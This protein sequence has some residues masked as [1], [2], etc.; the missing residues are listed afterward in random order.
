MS[1]AVE[2]LPIMLLKR[3]LKPVDSKRA[4]LL[5]CS[6]TKENKLPAY[7]LTAKVL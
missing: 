6:P 4:N 1:T 3:D 5:F 2:D 7:H